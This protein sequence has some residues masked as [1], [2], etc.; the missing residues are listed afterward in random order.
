MAGKYDFDTHFRYTLHRRV[1]VVNFEPK[2]YPVSIGL[3]IDIP[4]SSVM[5]FDVEAMQLKHELAFRDQLLIRGAPV[6]TPAA[7]Q[8]LIPATATFYICHSDEGLRPHSATVPLQKRIVVS[9]LPA[10]DPGYT[11]GITGRSPAVGRKA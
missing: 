4:D 11:S 10:N 1:E 5:V 9:V 2:Q 8:A 3:V 7:K 6:I